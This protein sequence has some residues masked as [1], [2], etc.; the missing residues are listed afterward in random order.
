MLARPTFRPHLHVEVVAGEGLVL[1]TETRH[2]ILPESLYALVAPYLDGH[3]SA[4]TIVAAL[5][6][7]A[8]PA[9]VRRVLADLERRGLLTEASPHDAAGDAALWA[10]HDV[11]PA[12]ATQRLATS[13]VSVDAVGEVD[14]A[15]FLEALGFVGVRVEPDA[16]RR[17]VLTDDYL[18]RELARCNTDA[19]AAG[20]EWLVV[21]PTGCIV[22]LGPVFRPGRTAC[23]ECLAQRLRAHRT[24]ENF[25]AQRN[26]RAEP[27]ALARAASAASAQ[28][29]ARIA[30][31]AVAAWLARDEAP[32]LEGAVVTIDV[33]S[34]CSETHRVVARPQCGACGDP[35][36]VGVDTARPLVLE[37]RRKTFARDGGHRTRAPEATVERFRHHVS[38]VSGAVPTL[39]RNGPPHDGVMHAYVAGANLA[40]PPR[41][42]DMLR[43]GLRSRT[44]GKG[45]SDAQARA[46]ALCEALE[47]YSGVFHGDEP[48]RQARLAELGDAAIHPNACMGFS[49]RQYRERSAWN[50]RGDFVQ[51]VPL[52]FDAQARISWTP[53]WSFTRS[54]TRYLPTALCF[55]EYPVF[56]EAAYCFACSNGNAAGNTLEEAILQGFLELV[57]RDSV[58]LWWYSRARRPPLALD[59]FDEPYVQRVEAY[60]A[61]RG[62]DLV[63]LDLT[64]DLQIP[65]CAAVSRRRDRH[66]EQI[67]L[68]FGAHLDPRIALLRAV[69][70]LNQMLMRVLWGDEGTDAIGGSDEPSL[71]QWLA[72]ATLAEHPYLAPDPTQPPRRAAHFAHSW[73][74]DL[75][76][77]VRYCQHV[78]ESRGM[79]LLVLDQTRPDIGLP[80]VKVIVPGLRHFWPRFAPGRLYDV[81]PQL[82]WVPT[83]LSEAQLNP[84]AMFL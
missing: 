56:P 9:E 29:A 36:D 25:L 19:L 64:S 2:I 27:L 6:G 75:R 63:V 45:A 70:E 11:D 30:A 21:K 60:L 52:P 15:P 16:A 28:L 65:V 14:P 37:S 59:G 46:S 62:R 44:G 71:R 43:T 50:A 68:G 33:R 48:R 22:W 24:V 13:A 58:A 69:T 12:I 82:G 72:T 8:E 1:L 26:R 84:I 39:E 81:P 38:W 57:E 83:S 78:V 49:D 42:L 53:V 18:R 54:A 23:W 17:V 10:S 77:D 3:H 66:P 76:D 67:V 73:T 55:Y 61:E 41:T 40:R 74:D 79:E 20:R 4:D 47:R 31:S 80:V 32:A 5:S 51:A 34:W 35:P 7:Y